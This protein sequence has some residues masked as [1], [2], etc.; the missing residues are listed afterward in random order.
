[1]SNRLGNGL[2]VLLGTQS[3]DCQNADMDALYTDSEVYFKLS[4][5]MTS[6]TILTI[7]APGTTIKPI[8]EYTQEQKDQ[9]AGLRQASRSSRHIYLCP[10]SLKV[11]RHRDAASDRRLSPMGIAMVEQ[12]RYHS[13]VHAGI[14]MEPRGRRETSKGDT[15]MA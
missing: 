11:C 14:K 13:T 15:G 3:R 8:Y 10:L 4:C 7:P 1:M 12:I 6:H 2:G 9:M 5:I